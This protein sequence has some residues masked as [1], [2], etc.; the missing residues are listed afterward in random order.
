MHLL[1]ILAELMDV[2]GPLDPPVI[3]SC[4]GRQLQL[5]QWPI[6]PQVHVL[7]PQRLEHVSQR[8]MCYLYNI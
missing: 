5:P 4:S 8:L 2:G 3:L 7:K 1:F 6:A